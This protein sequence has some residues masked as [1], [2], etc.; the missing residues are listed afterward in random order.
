MKKKDDSEEADSEEGFC[1]EEADSEEGCNNEEA[2][3]EEERSD[4]VRK[5]GRG[6]APETTKLTWT[7]GRF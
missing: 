4:E 1:N 2:G 7:D 6:I 5:E 3:A